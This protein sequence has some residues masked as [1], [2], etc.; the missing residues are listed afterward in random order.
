MTTRREFL[1]QTAAPAVLAATAASMTSADPPNR[2]HSTPTPL[3]TYKIAHTD[4]TVSRLAFG[5]AML[6]WDWS[7]SDFATRAIPVIQTAYDQGIDFFDLADV[8]GNGNSEIALGQIL[9]QSPGLRH[10]VIIQS[11]CGDRFKEG[12]TVDN[13]QEHI[14]GSVEGSLRRLNTDYLDLLL[15]HWPDSLVEPEDVAKAF[16]D[17]KRSGKVRYFGVSNHSPMQ[18]DLLCKY[19]RQPLVANQ[20]QLGLMHWDV[21]TQGFKAS[22][23]HSDE[24]VATLDYCRLHGVWV[25]A[26][27]PLKSESIGNPPSLLNPPENALPELRQAVQ[28][29][30]DLA[31][32]YEAT[33]AAIM[34]AWLLRHPAGISPI[35]GATKVEHVIEGCKADRIELTRVEWYTLLAAATKVQGIKR[36]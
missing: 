18:C 20:I 6:G 9:N 13:S 17:L 29:L 21:E 19:V 22:L 2:T 36:T 25:Q 8:Y 15:L 28:L 10:K 11:K 14:M 26:Y 35:I 34:I 5:C 3:K 7:S 27:S 4:L 23:T 16:D 32:K 24:G 30:S 1:V 31:T 33:P 12:G